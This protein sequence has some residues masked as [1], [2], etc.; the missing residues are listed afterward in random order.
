MFHPRLKRLAALFLLLLLCVLAW[1][2]QREHRAAHATKETRVANLI[3]PELLGR[4][5]AIEQ[6]ERQLDETLWA[7]E[8]RAEQCGQVLENLWDNLNRSTNKFATLRAFPIGELLVS[9]YSP[10]QILSDQISPAVPTEPLQTWKQPDWQKFLSGLETDGWSL[11]HVE[12]RQRAFDPA[13]DGQS[14][15]SR[16][17]FRAD[18]EKTNGLE[19]ATVEG[20]LLV[21]WATNNPVDAQPAISRLDARGL[22]IR[23]RK[24]EVAF[25]PVLT[26]TIQPLEKWLF[27][28]PLILYDLDGDGLSEIILPGKNLVYHRSVDGRY[29]PGPLCKYEP[30]RIFTAILADFDGDGAVDYLCAK[31]EGLILFHGSAEGTFNEPGR[32]VWAAKPAL[33]YGQVLAC[34]D[35]DG[36]GHLDL[37]LGQYKSP[38]FHGQMPTPYFDANDGDP[39]YL[40]V[41]D[42]KGNFSDVTESCGLASKR[43]RRCY[44]ASFV[45]TRPE[46]PLDLVVVSDFAGIDFYHNDGHGHF[47]DVTRSTIPEPMG[48]GMAHAFCDFNRDGLLDFLMIGMDSPAVDRLE[49]LGLRRQDTLEAPSA[50]SRLADGNHLFAGRLDG[51][52]T[53]ASLSPSVARSGWSW[54]CCAADFDNDGFPDV[55][56]V[57]GHESRA[58]VRDYDPEFWLHD[59]YVSGSTNNTAAELYFQSKFTRTRGRGDS[60]G[61]YEQNRFYLNIDANTFL[62][63]GHLL[64]LGLENDCRNAVADDLDGDG[65]MDVLVTTFEVWPA[66]KQTL[67]VYENH[68]PQVGNWIGFRFRERAH[69]KSPVGAAV[70]IHYRGSAAT[71][72]IVTGDS[73]RSQTATTLH[74]G[75]G[76]ATQVDWAEITWVDGTKRRIDRP[77]LNHYSVVP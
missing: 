20:E 55:Y 37:F 40:L 42:G 52:F 57:N 5:T 9:T 41:N 48:F 39:S 16:F 58:S 35:I 10:A 32:L 66:P 21:Q 54:G 73:Y 45:R 71:A 50:R 12:F 47:Q 27:I 77:Q 62:E 36:D 49:H 46:G 19:R 4:F 15:R 61:G 51:S 53:P 13:R 69:G 75:V 68:L 7:P 33:K 44:S 29:S 3:T 25:R 26:E 11:G 2:I 30:G 59:I 43:S 38:Y 56:I 74:F 1:R 76:N 14:E 31:P 63:A 17:S 23:S 65:K 67:R 60:Y 22:A 18:L 6:R 24:G 64:G 72:Q 28:D 8:R 70:T 34:G